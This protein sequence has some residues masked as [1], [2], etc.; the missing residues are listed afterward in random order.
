MQKGGGVEGGDSKSVRAATNIRCDS[1]ISVCSGHD[2]FFFSFLEK[3]GI[4]F[5]E[6]VGYVCGDMI[7]IP[8]LKIGKNTALR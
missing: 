7:L 1:S 6:G 2:E 3:M 8:R 5:S 4:F